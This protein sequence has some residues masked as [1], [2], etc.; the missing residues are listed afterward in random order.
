MRNEISYPRYKFSRLP[1]FETRRPTACQG[2]IFIESSR[3]VFPSSFLPPLNL[4][5]HF[6][7]LRMNFFN[8]L[9]W[10]LDQICFM[11]VFISGTT[12]LNE[13]WLFLF[14]ACTVLWSIDENGSLPSHTSLQYR[15]KSL[16]L[17][18]I[19]GRSEKS[20]EMHLYLYGS[21]LRMSFAG[22][23][24]NPMLANVSPGL[25]DVRYDGTKRN[26]YGTPR[27]RLFR[28]VSKLQFWPRPVKDILKLEPYL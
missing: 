13:K 17:T 20:R 14:S 18:Y 25:L 7:T 28:G 12:D 11:H 19:H 15:W 2:Q 27:E 3:N 10:K 5:L 16:Q 23:G 22:H 8:D 9:S 21:S 6:R 4:L 24:W 26:C 1:S